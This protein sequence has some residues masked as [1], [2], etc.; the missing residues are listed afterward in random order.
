MFL[1]QYDNT[2]LNL[3]RC[4]SLKLLVPKLLIAPLWW[5]IGCLISFNFTPVFVCSSQK[6]VHTQHGL[7]IKVIIIRT[8][9]L[10]PSNSDI[11]LHIR[12]IWFKLTLWTI[13]TTQLFKIDMFLWL[14]HVCVLIAAVKTF[15]FVEIWQ[16]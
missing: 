6:V 7:I 11:G 2:T 1:F 16:S 5:H 14:H 13:K 15:N 4:S 10:K 12:H 8:G 9:I 3:R